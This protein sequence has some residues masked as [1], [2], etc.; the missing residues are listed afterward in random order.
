MGNSKLSSLD[1]YS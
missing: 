1:C